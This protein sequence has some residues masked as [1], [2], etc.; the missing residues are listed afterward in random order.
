MSLKWEGDIYR[1]KAGDY[2]IDTTFTQSGEFNTIKYCGRI[3]GYKNDTEEA[4]QFCEAHAERN[5]NG[6]E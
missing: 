3:L 6:V 4:K 2:Q 1:Q 5:G